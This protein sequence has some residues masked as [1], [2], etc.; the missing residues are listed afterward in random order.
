MLSKILRSEYVRNVVTLILG[1]GVAQVLSI[2]FIP[3]YTRWFLPETFGF[4]SIV[5]NFGSLLAIMIFLGLEM[6]IPTLKN[7]TEI[8]SALNACFFSSF[9][10][11]SVIIVAL[12]SLSFFDMLSNK[13]TLDIL[14]SIVLMGVLISLNQLLM[15]STIQTGIFKYQAINNI[16]FVVVRFFITLSVFTVLDENAL[17]F[18]VYFAFIISILYLFS[19]LKNANFFPQ[20]KL[21]KEIGV[22]FIKE[23]YHFIIY[24]LPSSFMNIFLSSFPIIYLGLVFDATIAGLFGVFQR[25]MVAPLSLVNKA[26]GQV[27]LN[28]ATQ[29]IE[30]SMVKQLCVKIVLYL[31]ATF[32]LFIILYIFSENVFYFMLGS[33]WSKV[34]EICKICLPYIFL[35]FCVSPISNIYVAYGETKIFFFINLTFVFLLT[36]YFSIFAH[37]FNSALVFLSHFN[38][39]MM[40]YYLTNLLAIFGILKRK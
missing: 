20:V 9:I 32:P 21:S 35:S 30:K 33:E 18:G 8:E 12:F 25:I 24:N 31:G 17:I 39:I 11:I 28:A 3:I 19:A 16:L 40:I 7:K 23:H 26:F 15:Q 10:I 29:N 5:Q 6:S 37:N 38:V 4:L 2:A 13:F 27:L 34:G 36:L 1:S 14:L 22:I